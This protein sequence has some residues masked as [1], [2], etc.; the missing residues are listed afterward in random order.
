MIKYYL[1]NAYLG[2]DVE[3]PVFQYV[4]EKCL[5]PA[6]SGPQGGLAGVSSGGELTALQQSMLLLAES[7]ESGAICGQFEQVYRR[8]P[9]LAI[10]DSHLPQNANKNRLVFKLRIIYLHFLIT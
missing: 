8:N 1:Q 4:P 5:S 3:E 10:T 7:L 6:W 9:S 2:E